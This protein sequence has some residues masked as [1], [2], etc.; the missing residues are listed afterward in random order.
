MPIA[1]IKSKLVYYS[2]IPKCGGSS[3]EKYLDEVADS[4][5]FLDRRFSS[6]SKETLWNQ[7]SPQHIDGLSLERLFPQ[8]IFFDSYFAVVRDP[9][10]RFK[11]AFKF[12]KYIEKKIPQQKSISDFALS[13]SKADVNRLGFCDN[14]FMP[15][16]RF[17]M[18]NCDYRIFKLEN[19]LLNVK[20]WFEAEILEGETSFEIGNENVS[21]GSAKIDKDLSLS[22]KADKHL[23]GIYQQDFE[24]FKY[25]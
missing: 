4:I 2:H 18:P 23:R 8:S 6:H 17:F 25:D 20:L 12:Q 14:H 24:L 1:R 21:I 5:S 11:S 7:S 16:V 15:M 9:I 10:A 13:L 19:G 22:K 3:I